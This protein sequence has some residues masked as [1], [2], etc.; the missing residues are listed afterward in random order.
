[1]SVDGGKARVILNALVTPFEVTENAPMLDLLW[2]SAF[3]W[4]IRPR[5]ITGDAAYGTTENIAAVERAGIRAYVPLSGAG[6]ARPFFSKEEFSYDTEEDLYRCPA[7]EVLL[8]R[9]KNKARKL[10]VYKAKATTCEACELRPK[11]HGQQDRPPSAPLL[12]GGLRRSGPLLPRDLPLREGFA[13]EAGLG[14]AP[15]RRGQGPAR[16]EEVQAQASGEGEYR[17]ATDRLMPERQAAAHLRY[18]APEKRG[19][20]RGPPGIDAT[21]VSRPPRCTKAL[22]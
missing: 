13:Q 19:P 15:V 10:T 21:S 4:K 5:R 12:R 20:G 9:A 17:G 6:K 22:R 16:D 2:R 11:C 8:P 18:P 7:G 14:G 1:M 3:R